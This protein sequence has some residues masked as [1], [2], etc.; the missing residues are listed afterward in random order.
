MKRR[1]V[2]NAAALVL[3]AWPPMLPAQA[4]PRTARVAF[5]LGAAPNP[6]TTRDI[7]EP[8]VHSLSAAGF[9]AGRNLVIDYRWA[10]GKPERLPGLLA[11][12]L[13]LRPDGAAGTISAKPGWRRTSPTSRR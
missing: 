10:E 5:L 13:A 8:F 2:L 6:F 9:I 11:E 7:V 3:A 1:R 12:L 4:P